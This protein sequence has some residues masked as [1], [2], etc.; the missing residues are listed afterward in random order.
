MVKVNE[1]V[2]FDARTYSYDGLYSAL[3]LS[4]PSD[5]ATFKNGI[6]RYEIDYTTPWLG[7]TVDYAKSESLNC[8]LILGVLGSVGTVLFGGAN[9]GG[10]SSTTY[11]APGSYEGWLWVYGESGCQGPVGDKVQINVNP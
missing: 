10:M 7:W 5:S 2:F 6:N 1:T 3:N 8:D 4:A 11:G 9:T